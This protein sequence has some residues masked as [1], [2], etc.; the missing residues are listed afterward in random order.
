MDLRLDAQHLPLGSMATL[1]SLF[2]QLDG[3][4]DAKL[5]LKGEPGSLAFEGDFSITNG[6]LTIP[7]FVDPLVAN[8]HAS[9][10]GHR[11]DAGASR[12][13]RRRR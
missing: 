9:M 11:A 4:G 13:S 10:K 2:R 7:T 8:R 12:R 5:A 6:R 1:I 3:T